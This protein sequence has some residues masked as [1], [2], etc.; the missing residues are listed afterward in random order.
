M[1]GQDFYDGCITFTIY[2]NLVVY[3]FSALFAGIALEIMRRT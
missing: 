1:S 2:F 3:Y